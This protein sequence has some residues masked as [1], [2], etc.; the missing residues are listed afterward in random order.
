MES[1]NNGYDRCIIIKDGFA[2]ASP[3]LFYINMELVEPHAKQ[4]YIV[5]YN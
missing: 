4:P 5:V 2:Y 3:F 1:C